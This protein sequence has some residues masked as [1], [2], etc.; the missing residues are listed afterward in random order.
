M[1]SDVH[2]KNKRL[3][4]NLLTLNEMTSNNVQQIQQ[5]PRVLLCQEHDENELNYYCD[6]CKKLICSYCTIKDHF[7]HSHDTVKKMAATHR[8]TLEEIAYQVEEILGSL[9]FA[10]DCIEI[11]KKKIAKQGDDVNMKIDQLYDGL[12]LKLN[13]QREQVKQQVHEAL[14]LKEK[15]VTLQL[16]EVESMQSQVMGMKELNNVLEKCSDQEALSAKEQVIGQMK[17]L[18]ERYSV[19]NTEPVQADMMEVLVSD[20]PLPQFCQLL[21]NIDPVNTA[22]E[23]LPRKTYKG[24]KVEFQIVTKYGNN[25]PC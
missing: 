2:K 10:H 19:L 17:Q 14:T 3:N 11:A 1:C 18:T 25:L 4:H 8:I 15:M 16:E 23:R 20:I 9:C 12:I 6:T 22:I 24:S 7:G 13:Q 21:V 5:K